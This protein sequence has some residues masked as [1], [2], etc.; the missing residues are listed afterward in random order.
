LEQYFE[1]LMA[2]QVKVVFSR[3]MRVTGFQ[4]QGVDTRP[5]GGG[6][7][8]HPPVPQ[9]EFL[10]IGQCHPGPGLHPSHGGNHLPLMMSSL[11][12]LETLDKDGF[13]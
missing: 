4:V 12:V 8:H 3:A 11:K 7:A 5:V 13:L 6:G 1:S 9:A 2:K 10:K